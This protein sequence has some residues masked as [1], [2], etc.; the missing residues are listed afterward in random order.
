M[1]RKAGGGQGLKLKGLDKVLKRLDKLP[2][3]VARAILKK[4]LT[5]ALTPMADAARREAPVDTGQTRA[6]VKIT[7]AR[8]KKGYIFANVRVGAGDY[9]GEQFYA[10][11]GIY[12]FERNGILYPPDNWLGRAFDAT[13][14]AV[15][16]R[17]VETIGD[18]VAESLKS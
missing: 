13:H 2:D 16:A 3:K 1:S 8:S 12:G 10:S 15:R 5:S 14:E 7:P 9:K 18:A 4:G 17:A 6:A 11:F